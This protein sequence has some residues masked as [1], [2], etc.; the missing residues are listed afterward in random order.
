[1]LG[2]SKNFGRALKEFQF[3]YY[4]TK[5][6]SVY[7]LFFSLRLT[8]FSVRIKLARRIFKQFEC[9]LFFVYCGRFEGKQRE[10]HKFLIN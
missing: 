8:D 5:I 7:S 2:Y 6:L 9:F 1:M 4:W 3:D 10:I